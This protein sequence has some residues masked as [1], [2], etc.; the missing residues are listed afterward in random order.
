MSLFSLV[1]YEEIKASFTMSYWIW[2]HIAVSCLFLYNLW[3]Q[4]ASWSKFK[5]QWYNQAAS[6]SYTHQCVECMDSYSTY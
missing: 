3:H 2:S 1:K 5:L 6:P 4:Q